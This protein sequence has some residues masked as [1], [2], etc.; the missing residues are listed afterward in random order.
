MNVSDCIHA[1]V[2][3]SIHAQRSDDKIA[4]LLTKLLVVAHLLWQTYWLAWC[5]YISRL[6]SHVATH[7]GTMSTTVAEAFTFLVDVSTPTVLGLFPQGTLWP[8]AMQQTLWLINTADTWTDAADTL[9][10]AADTLTD[11]ADTLTDAADTLTDAA[12]TLTD[13]ADTLSLHSD[14][15]F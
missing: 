3:Q 2:G 5:I 4:Q 13:A 7:V 9:T 12:D 10:D 1:A 11:A 8:I 6:L 15:V 14:T